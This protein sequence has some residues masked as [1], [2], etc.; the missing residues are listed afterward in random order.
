M[1]KFILWGTLL[2][3]IGLMVFGSATA[4]LGA[5]LGCPDWPLCYGSLLPPE[6]SVAMLEYIHRLLAA[7]TSVFVV[8]TLFL[9]VK[10]YRGTF[11]FEAAVW[12]NIFLL[13]QILIG[14]LTVILKMP[15]WVSMSHAFFGLLTVL[16]S[17]LLLKWD[18]F[19]PKRFILSGD[20][21]GRL[22]FIL[23]ILMFVQIMLGTT[24][25]KAMAGFA[26]G[27]DM[28]LCLGEPWTGKVLIQVVHRLFGYVLLGVS[29]YFTFRGRSRG[30]F[31]LVSL[32]ILLTGVFGALSAYSML[33]PTMVTTHYALS[34]LLLVMLFWRSLG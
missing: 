30:W 14:G 23:F 3:M 31:A 5:C 26:C 21:D 11:L 8:A 12:L 25:R 13:A 16:A 1:R 24:V 32:L 28:F 22:S 19:P 6:H 18:D 4:A 29:L 2:S 34:L 10:R 33:S 15:F 17:A 9:A 7:L 20:E 27:Q